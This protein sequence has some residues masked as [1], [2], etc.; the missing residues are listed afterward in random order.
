LSDSL[1]DQLKALGLAGKKPDRG[2]RK[3]KNRPP[4]GA[5][6]GEDSL[7]LSRA[8]ALKARDEHRQAD[9]ARRKKQA[10]DRKRR[11]INGRIRQIVGQHR[12]NMKEAEISRNFMFKGRIRKIYVTADQLKKLNEG[13]LGVVYLSGGYH[14]LHRE[15]VK[16]VIGLSREH[17]PDLGAGDDADGD[18]PVPDDLVW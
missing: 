16:S 2:N 9:R 14:L 10:E 18:Y 8:Y 5:K 7:S 13:E 15:H 4:Q 17:V 12:L 6:N 11:E 3:R 1:Q